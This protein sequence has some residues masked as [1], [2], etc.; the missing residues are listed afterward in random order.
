M[1]ASTPAAAVAVPAIAIDQIVASPSN[2]RKSFDETY[3]AEL[4]Q[5]IKEHGLIQP[6]TVR[7]NP[8]DTNGLWPYQLVVGECRWRAAKL[9]GLTEIAA[10]W[11]DLDD[12]QV[13]EIQV[14]EN[15][16]RRDV[17]PIEEADGYEQLM[18]V[19]GYKAE[20]IAEKIGKSRSYVYA[21]TKLAALCSE[22]RKIVLDE[23]IDASIALI[24]ARLG[25]KDQ[26]AVLKQMRYQA[27]A[28]NPL[29]FRDAKYAI[30]NGF[31]RELLCA[32]FP[33]D[34]ATLVKAAGSCTACPKR[35]GNA[36]ELFPDIDGTDVCTDVKCH[37]AK[38]AAVRTRSI[39][40]ATQR[41]IKVYVGEEAKTVAAQGTEWSIDRE[42]WVVLDDDID[43]DEEGRTYR[44]ALG[45]DAPVAAM[46]EVRSNNGTAL[47]ELG[48]PTAIAKALKK[49][50]I[51]LPESEDAEPMTGAPPRSTSDYELWDEKIAEEKARRMALDQRIVDHLLT[52]RLGPIDLD[53]AIVALAIAHLR[54]A[55]LYSEI[56]ET[57][58]ARLGISVPDE[59]NES[60]ELEKACAIMAEWTIGRALAYLASSLAHNDTHDF[61]DRYEEEIKPALSMQAIAEALGLD[62][63]KAEEKPILPQLDPRPAWPFPVAA[64]TIA[65]ADDAPLQVGDRVKIKDG[66][67]GPNR[68]IRKV[69]GR[70]GVIE[71]VAGES[72]AVRLGPGRNG[73]ASDFA[74]GDLQL[75]P[76]A[77]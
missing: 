71:T 12:K 29:S 60:E 73:L 64:E 11:R 63:A 69:C 15:L 61:S 37:A 40:D 24:V 43:G 21:R 27:G 35:S 54:Q 45:K 53:A 20:E 26:L 66:V 57:L 56:D 67:K 68:H 32:A 72:Y 14:I 2:P 55:V 7:P 51:T 31:T 18:T 75:L 1:N 47:I 50:G 5:S 17:H 49:A 62:E 46:V 65:A 52:A 48:E 36:H 8:L 10:F 42:T 77:A 38:H 76:A 74:A 28:G 9:A 13:L 6:I 4:A 16:Q 23:K 30:R 22:A 58:L 19:H 34:D 44:Q 33:L 3:L 39:N 59:Y 70:E 41:G 25:E